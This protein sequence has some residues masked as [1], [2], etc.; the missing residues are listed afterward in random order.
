MSKTQDAWPPLLA[1]PVA[2][3]IFNRPDTTQ[4]VF[5]RIRA[6]RPALLLVIAD[7]PRAAQPDDAPRCRAARAVID[8]VDWPCEVRTNYA[9]QNMGCGPRLA[10]GLDWVFDQVE[11][12]I[13]LEDDCVPEAD[14]FPFCVQLLQQYRHDPRVMMISGSN[15]VA[16]LEIAESY[17][18]SRWYNIWGWATWRRAWQL[19]DFALGEWA[20]VRPAQQVEQA[21]TNKRVSRY[22]CH[23]FDLIRD[24]KI[25]T[26]DIQ[27]FYTCLR[28][29]GLCIV[30][31][32]NLIANIGAAGTHTEAGHGGAHPTGKLDTQ[33]LLHPATVEAHSRFDQEFYRARFRPIWQSEFERYRM[34]LRLR[35]RRLRHP[36]PVTSQ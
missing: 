14:F 24:H 19:Y 4:L 10:S 21:Y 18:F 5:E 9:A 29:S 36:Q 33:R 8:Q 26:W 6:V 25:D 2:F 22:L 31:A 35:W 23:S 30:P 1:T 15:L 17:L 16:N 11:E 27:W 3:F 32:V 34:A 13:I 12:A 28:H 7:G 20:S